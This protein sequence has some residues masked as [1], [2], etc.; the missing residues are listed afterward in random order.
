LL[1]DFDVVWV[2]LSWEPEA[3]D[4]AR[5]LRNS[6]IQPVR[7]LRPGS[8]PL[9]VAGGPLTFSNPD[10]AAAF[11]DAVFLGEADGAFRDLAS[12]VNDARDR[13]DALVRL[14]AVP[15][16]WVPAIH[17]IHDPPVALISAPPETPPAR[18]VLRGEP[19]EFGDAFI[20][21]V[22]RG[23]PRGCT[24]CVARNGVRRCSFF[25]AESIFAAIPDDARRVGLL[26]AAVSDHPDLFRIVETLHRRGVGVTLGSVRA[27]RVTPELMALL[28]Q[29]GLRT[30]TVAADGPSEVL[31]AFL[32]KG[33]HADDLRRCAD[34]AR[35]HGIGR[36]RLYVM[37]GLPG[38]TEADIEELADLV[39]DLAGRVRLAVSVSPFVPKRF[40]PLADSPFAGAKQLKRRLAL[41]SRRVGGVAA[42]KAT[43]PRHA[44]LEW[45]LSHVR[46]ED[47]EAAVRDAR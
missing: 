30:L 20:V 21:E 31:R 27:D 46:G 25:S 6:G 28:A 22:G 37:V 33:I 23:C 15:G 13:E 44:E 39:R 47:A 2:S 42:L 34:L 9:V 43:S 14:A 11:A 40:T 36:L 38:E 5:A 24:F 4:V 8:D 26:G 12:A 10:L 35:L 1:R 29:S 16:T 45:I 32:H 41:L 18:T 17:G 7:S 19:N 3:L